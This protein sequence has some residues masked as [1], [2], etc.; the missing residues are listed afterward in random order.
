MLKIDFDRGIVETSSTGG[1]T[2][3]PIG[4][5]EAFR[6]ISR[7]WLRSGW[8]AKYVYGFSWMGR[9]IIQ[10]PEDLLRIQEGLYR[11]KPDVIIETRNAHVGS[12]LFIAGHLKVM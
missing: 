8:D 10:L 6:L 1:N 2:A 7:A 3:Y 12:L 11:L 9:P 4:S 5:P